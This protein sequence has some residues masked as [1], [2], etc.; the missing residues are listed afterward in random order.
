MFIE[1]CLCIPYTIEIITWI[2][3]QP[4]DIVGCGGVGVCLSKKICWVSLLRQIIEVFIW[5]S[6]FLELE[7]GK[8]FWCIEQYIFVLNFTQYQM[9][10]A[11]LD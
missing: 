10:T 2:K 8:K 5:N 6:K 9:I 7:L 1:S 3:Q 11:L 4:V